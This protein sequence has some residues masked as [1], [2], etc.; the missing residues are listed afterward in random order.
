MQDIA[1]SL[2]ALADSLPKLLKFVRRNAI[3]IKIIK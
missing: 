3:G 1:H 2:T